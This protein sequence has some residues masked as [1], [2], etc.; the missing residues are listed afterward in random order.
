MQECARCVCSLVRRQR[1]VRQAGMRFVGEHR[2]TVDEHGSLSD[3][4]T[5]LVSDSAVA[6]VQLLGVQRHRGE[7][8][9]G[10]TP[11][12]HCFA[13]SALH[14]PHCWRTSHSRQP[15]GG[16]AK[17]QQRQPR[18]VAVLHRRGAQRRR[19]QSRTALCEQIWTIGAI[20]TNHRL[21]LS[22]CMLLEA[23]A[24]RCPVIPISLRVIV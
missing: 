14:A 7:G 10:R 16:A 20:I 12:V 21:A 3:E 24:T 5:L 8:Q 2:W 15:Q 6:E 9:V 23:P 4:Q 22:A 17:P 18:I 13:R 1:P 19:L 11:P